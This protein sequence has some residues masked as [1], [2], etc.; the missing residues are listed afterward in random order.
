MARP[1]DNDTARSPRRSSAGTGSAGAPRHRIG[2]DGRRRTAP[3]RAPVDPVGAVSDVDSWREI[4]RDTIF[5]LDAT[6]LR[7]ADRHAYTG[8]VNIHDFG[9]VSISD[10]AS[11]PVRVAR[12]P[13]LIRRNPVD[14]YLLLI[15]VR[16][17]HAAIGTHHNRLRHGDAVLV[18][19]TQ[20]YSLTADAFAHYLSLHVPRAAVRRD[21]RAAPPLGHIIPAQDP[22]LRVLNAVV[23]ELV[24]S[25]LGRPAETLADLGHTAYELL[26]STLRTAPEAGTWGSDAQLSRRTQLARMREFIRMHLA[27]PDLS[28]RTLAAAFGVSTRYVDLVFREGNSSPAGFIRDA[29][30][31]EARR[32]LADPRQ[33]HHSVTSVA[34]SV[35]FT[36]PSVL[37]RGF[38]RRY[39]T[40]PGEY[41]REVLAG[42]AG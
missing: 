39:G 41:R 36:D 35:G 10:V 14:F 13:R 9:A 31:D 34:W 42:T 40:T 33:R 17:S 26:V 21:L 38:R 28:P 29:R 25:P 22:T 3:R 4:L 1:Q 37:T 6:P 7:P 11:D 16:P 2:P 18:D 5:Q 30:L 27:D 19:S 20:P 23:T 24:R 8:W 32:M 12:T 15:A